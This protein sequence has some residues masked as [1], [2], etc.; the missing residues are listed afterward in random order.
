MIQIQ[1]KIEKR[2]PDLLTL[3]PRLY[4][5]SVSRCLL[6][7]SKIVK[8][9]TFGSLIF[10]ILRVRLILQMFQLQ[11]MKGKLTPD[12]LTLPT[13]FYDVSVS[14]NRFSKTEM[15]QFGASGTDG[16]TKTMTNYTKLETL[17]NDSF[18]QFY[19]SIGWT[20]G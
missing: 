19:D 17:A 18:S 8:F 15:R 16:L 11:F 9:V 10:G 13:T 12:F 5:L 4:D 20:V 6:T 1:F 3:F 2:R 7:N 14:C